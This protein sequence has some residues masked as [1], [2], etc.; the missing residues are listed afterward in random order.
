MIVAMT[1]VM[2]IPPSDKPD[3]AIDKATERLRTNQ[4]VTIVEPGTRLVR[5]KPIPKMIITMTI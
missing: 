2:A 1:G 5:A 3:D 4:R